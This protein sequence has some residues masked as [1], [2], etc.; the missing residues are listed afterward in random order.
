MYMDIKDIIVKGAKA[1]SAQELK[2][3]AAKENMPLTDEQAEEYFAELQEYLKKQQ[4]GE[5][6][7]DEL[8][9]VNGGKCKISCP[10]VEPGG[11]CS[12]WVCAKCKGT[13]K[14]EVWASDRAQ[15]VGWIC[16]NCRVRVQCINCKYCKRAIVNYVC[17]R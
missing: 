9:D 13:K 12:G 1:N 6:S 10:N 11:W 5:L 2:E 15:M 16:S 3:L 8:D 7:D 14:T 17:T 4:T